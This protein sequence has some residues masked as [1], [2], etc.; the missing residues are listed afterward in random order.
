[1]LTYFNRPISINPEKLPILY[2]VHID[3]KS[4]QTE[5]YP[6][7]LSLSEMF[8]GSDI[9]YSYDELCEHIDQTKQYASEYNNYNVE[10]SN[11]ATFRNLKIG[12]IKGKCVIISKGNSPSI[13]FIIH[14]E[15]LKAAIE[16]FSPPLTEFY[17]E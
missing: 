3:F 5:D 2:T 8:F 15:K 9:F 6:V 14:H 10:L 17:S 12:I 7:S 1:M 13:H 11:T 16:S 4:G